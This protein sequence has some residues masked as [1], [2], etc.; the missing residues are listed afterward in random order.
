MEMSDEADTSPIHI[1]MS[2]FDVSWITAGASSQI[3]RR[4]EAQACEQVGSEIP[5]ARNNLKTERPCSI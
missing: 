5:P 1:K 3:L 4:A 2:K